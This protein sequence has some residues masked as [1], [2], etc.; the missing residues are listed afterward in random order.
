MLGESAVGKTSIIQNYIKQEVSL[1]YKPTVG[2]DMHKKVL[3]I[4]FM[5]EIKKVT[6][7]IW[8]TVG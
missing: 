5:D 7:Q 8:D 2:A 4:P 1:K 3:Q 6:L